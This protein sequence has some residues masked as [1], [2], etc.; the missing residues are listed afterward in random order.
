[1]RQI[2]LILV[3]I[4]I[5]LFFLLGGFASALI[6]LHFRTEHYTISIIHYNVYLVGFVVGCLCTNIIKLFNNNNK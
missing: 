6:F 2:A 3:Q 5:S 4:L 1:M